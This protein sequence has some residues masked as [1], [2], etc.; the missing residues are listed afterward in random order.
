MVD[1]L[2]R[3]M[4]IVCD[5]GK[6]SAVRPDDDIYEAGFSSINALQLLI[7]LESALEVSIP[8]DRFI[9][10]RSPRAICAIIEQSKQEQAAC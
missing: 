8:D 10:A 7:E 4:S 2:Q 6:I 3:V 9:N 5:V 1:D